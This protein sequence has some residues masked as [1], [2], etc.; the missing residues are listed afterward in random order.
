MFCFG[1]SLCRCGWLAVVYFSFSVASAI[2]QTGSVSG[3]VWLQDG[4]FH[5]L[6]SMVTNNS[7]VRKVSYV[8]FHTRGVDFTRRALKQQPLQSS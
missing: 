6:N 4:C 3:F 1:A 2:F 7:C 8:S 5:G